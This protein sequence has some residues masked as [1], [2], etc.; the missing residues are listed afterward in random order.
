MIAASLPSAVDQLDAHI[1][2]Q[3]AELL[4]GAETCS[5]CGLPLLASVLDS[6]RRKAWVDTDLRAIDTPHDRETVA[7]FLDRGPTR[8]LGTR[9]H[10]RFRTDCRT[11]A[12]A[13]SIAAHLHHL[14]APVNAITIGGAP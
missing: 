4:A 14:G 10:G 13:V 3:I 12:E 7:A 8:P 6:H 1:N 5:H 2:T 11:A 9:L